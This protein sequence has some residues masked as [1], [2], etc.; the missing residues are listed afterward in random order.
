MVAVSS[1]QVRAFRLSGHYLDR[2][3][4]AGSL[5][6]AAGACGLQNTPPGTAALSLAARVDGLTPQDVDRALA[7]DKTLLQTWGIRQSLYIFPTADLPVFTTAIEPV[8][9]E[10]WRIAV[11]G[12]VNVLDQVGMTATEAVELARKGVYDVLDGTELTKRELG[13][14]LGKQMPRKLR[15]WFTADTFSEFS[16]VLVRPLGTTGLFVITPR[17]GSEAS[18]ARLDQWLGGQVP[19]T[20]PDHARAE[21]V[22]RY[23]RCYGPS[24]VEQYA[25]WAGIAPDQAKSS[26][27]LVENQ[28]TGVRFEGAESWLHQADV[29]TARKSRPIKGT[30]LVPAYDPLLQLR[31]RSTLV[32]D[33]SLHK[34]VW[35]P[36]GNPGVVLHDGDVVALWRARK[37]GKKYAVTIEPVTARQPDLDAIE[38]EV[39]RFAPFRGCTSTTITITP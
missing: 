13:V 36:T 4:P 15:K 6:T 37:Q 22:R 29:E 18:F 1:R 26:W 24:T 8:D 32:P 20:E 31:D 39:S 2:R 25:A 14:R 35:K 27:T 16:A 21:L 3:L 30:R 19:S 7:D 9:E 11:T 10:S 5:D 38:A 34:R 28:L 17:S 33:I 12:F 23:L